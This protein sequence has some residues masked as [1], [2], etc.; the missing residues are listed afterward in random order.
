[1]R[2]I[3]IIPLSDRN[4]ACVVPFS[5]TCKELYIFYNYIIKHFNIKKTLT[6]SS[7]HRARVWT[8]IFYLVHLFYTLKYVSS[9]TIEIVTLPYLM[10]M[11]C[12]QFA[13]LIVHLTNHNCCRGRFS[14]RWL[15]L[16]VDFD[17]LPF[18]ILSWN[19]F[20]KPFPVSETFASVRTF[21]FSIRSVYSFLHAPFT[22]IFYWNSWFVAL[23]RSISCF[24]V[25]F[26]FWCSHVD[27][28]AYASENITS[29]LLEQTYT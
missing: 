24:L 8:L 28:C 19:L 10:L 11:H 29:W 5:V 2:L 25:Y 21:S 15:H 12:P 17:M 26:V 4:C 1:M 9:G 20:D 27:A 23:Y 13:V 7:S 22:F 18:H 16:G 6:H 14:Q 3:R